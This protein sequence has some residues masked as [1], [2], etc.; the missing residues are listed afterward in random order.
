[1]KMMNSSGDSLLHEVYNFNAEID[2]IHMGAYTIDKNIPFTYTD[3]TFKIDSIYSVVNGL[4]IAKSGTITINQQNLSIDHF[5]LLPYVSSK[6]FKNNRTRSN[7]R[8][9]VE[10]PILSLKDT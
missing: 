3:Y 1:L 9:L 4:Q 6:E 5:R 7:T 2:G 8:F 10:V